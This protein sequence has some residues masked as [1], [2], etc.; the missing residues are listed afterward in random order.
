VTSSIDE[1]NGIL[2]PESGHDEY[3]QQIVRHAVTLGDGG[4]R[5]SDFP[6]EARARTEVEPGNGAHFARLAGDPW[7]AA[8]EV[9][10]GQLLSRM[11]PRLANATVVVVLCG[12]TVLTLAGLVDSGTSV[13]GMLVA[14][15][16]AA[17]LMALQFGYFSRPGAWLRRRYSY[18]AL[19]AQACL[20]YLP[21]FEFRLFWTSFPG[22]V[23]GGALIALPAAQALPVLVA[24]VAS[25]AVIE[26]ELA[27]QVTSVAYALSYGVIST[28][29]TALIAFGLT[30]MA[31]LV[32]E[33]HG[34]QEELSRMA[35]AEE[36]LRLA[37]D[38]HDVLG[39]SLSAI[40]LKSELTYRL[41]ADQPERAREE[42]ADVLA[43]AR[44][45][46]TEVR[47]VASGR[48]ELSLED[49]F[50]SARSVLVAAGIDAR[51]RRES[52]VLPSAVATVLATLSQ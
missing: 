46:L 25:V 37:R 40:T 10:W 8:D 13:D 16:L 6:H 26:V 14:L 12:F 5:V 20:A 32:G 49:E 2:L 15:V 17:A 52:V 41:I 29:L 45:A 38:V 33:I 34:A 47:M 30:R 43:L 23:A 39:L 19:A 48:Q 18:L 27:R 24:V 28:L 51:I 21:M 11:A 3:G 9:A 50:A 1:D 35:V 7:Q 36:R 42:L 31:R 44:R 22:L 4:G